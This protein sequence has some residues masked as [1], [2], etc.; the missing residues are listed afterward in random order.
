MRGGAVAPHEERFQQPLRR[1]AL[2]FEARAPH[3]VRLHTLRL[4]TRAAAAGEHASP[5]GPTHPKATNGTQKTR[6]QEPKSELLQS[7]KQSSRPPRQDLRKAT[8]EEGVAEETFGLSVC[9]QSSTRTTT[10]G[11]EVS[12]A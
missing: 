6:Q 9:T 8:G 10:G 12:G 11:S 4:A 1:Q 7:P 3:T 2:C 5:S